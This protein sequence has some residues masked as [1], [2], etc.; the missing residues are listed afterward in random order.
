MENN[1]LPDMLCAI[2]RLGVI[3]MNTSK[4]TKL[5]QC[6]GIQ[7]IV[8]GIDDSPVGNFKFGA[9]VPSS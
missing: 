7:C 2:A 4:T 9:Q 8:V 1:L 6:Y 3:E 5:F